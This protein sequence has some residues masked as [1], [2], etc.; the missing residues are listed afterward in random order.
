MSLAL[1]FGS[2]LLKNNDQENLL[3]IANLVDSS[4]FDEAAL[5][6]KA[7][8][9][10]KSEHFSQNQK[11]LLKT[12]E[13]SIKFEELNKS[14]L[15]SM[16]KLQKINDLKNDLN[17]VKNNFGTSSMD[18]TYTMAI[19]IWSKTNDKIIAIELQNQNS[20]TLQLNQMVNQMNMES[21]KK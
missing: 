7:T 5:L 6:L 9:F 11:N 14:N 3:K 10:Q 4:N 17:K 1:Y 21:K 12:S 19:N 16:M 2:T 15:D 8:S 13:L 20:A 18:P